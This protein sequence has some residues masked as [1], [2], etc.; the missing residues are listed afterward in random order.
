MRLQS[1]FLQHT[2]NYRA[3]R[4]VYDPAGLFKYLRGKN[5]LLLVSF[6]TSA[7]K[8]GFRWIQQGNKVSTLCYTPH[9]LS[10][11]HSLSKHAIYTFR[12]VLKRWNN[13][14]S[15]KVLIKSRKSLMS[16]FIINT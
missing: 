4:K 7:N 13:S 6:T 16:K 15:I 10:T 8:A 1:D 12:H 14:N 9:M 5:P 2:A 11:H 3:S